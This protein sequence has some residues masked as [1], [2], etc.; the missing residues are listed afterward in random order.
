MLM[1]RRLLV[2]ALATA[3]LA[4]E[5]TL[6]QIVFRS[7]R[8]LGREW[9]WLRPIAARYLAAFAGRT[10]PRLREVIGF[11]LQDPGFQDAWS[12][13]VEELSVQHWLTEPQ[14]MQPVDA[15][16]N[17]NVP[18]LAAAGD[19]AN[20]LRLDIGELEWFADL[21]GLCNKRTSPQLRHYHYA[22]A[23]KRSGNARLL[24]APKA[25][26]KS[27]QRQILAGIL[28][29]VPAHPAVHGFIKHRSIKTF[30]A[31]HIGKRVVLRMDLQDFF[32]TFRAARIQSFFRTI[33]YPESVADLL[34][35]ICTN[36]VPRDIWKGLSVEMNRA[37]L[38][39]ASTFYARRHL[40]QGAPTSPALANLCA[41]RMDCR[42]AG[43]ARCAGAEYT[44]YAD[45]LAFSSDD[46]FEERVERFSTHIAAIVIEEGFTVQHRK[47]RV[48]RQGVR[49]NLAGLVA[50]VR[51]NV[52][53]SEFD[54]LKA[55]LTNCTRF[56][57]A[58]Q[59]RDN[60]PLFRAHLEGRV[61][62]VEQVNPAKAQRLRKILEKIDW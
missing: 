56:G 31:P 34:A 40:P 46:G 25:R 29:R 58:S 8:V 1:S 61:G 9:Q 28:E 45:D 4:G 21:K 49:Q 20:W 10:R 54:R 62:F 44:R 5:N 42:L 53:R 24:E 19:L 32:P 14:Q 60:H 30:V 2:R 50:N 7:E 38:H 55:I 27:V 15:A 39:E 6:E 18:S 43:L 41:Y 11:V 3:M 36:S 51:P 17:W 48:M 47:T 52:R 59:N 22:A 37:Q 16:A 33:G 12:K 26:L 13:H 23:I 57:P 35:G